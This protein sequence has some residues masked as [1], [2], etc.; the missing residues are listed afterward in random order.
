MYTCGP[1]GEERADEVLLRVPLKP[2]QSSVP[3]TEM[4]E[5]ERLR[6]G[7][8]VGVLQEVSEA[9]AAHQREGVR[10]AI[11]RVRLLIF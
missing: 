10:R 6:E 7:E 9:C 2:L 4:Q 11:C 3:E 5:D 1:V 8:V